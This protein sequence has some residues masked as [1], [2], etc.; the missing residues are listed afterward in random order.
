MMDIPKQPL[1]SDSYWYGSLTEREV[2]I[3]AGGSDGIDEVKTA[4]VDSTDL[5][6]RFSAD[7]K[8]FSKHLVMSFT[9]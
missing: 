8:R 1:A 3:N 9:Y 7:A 2:D 4:D 6:P 5:A